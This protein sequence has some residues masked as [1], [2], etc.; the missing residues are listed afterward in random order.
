M[1][2]LAVQLRPG[3]TI[4]IHGRTETVTSNELSPTGS[5]HIVT[6]VASEAEAH[7]VAAFKKIHVI[8]R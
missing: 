8:D 2:K 7:V 1:E 5:C 3:D 6:D 4:V